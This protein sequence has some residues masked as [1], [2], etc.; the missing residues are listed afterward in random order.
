MGL[1]T[2]ELPPA[3]HFHPNPFTEELS[4]LAPPER[5]LR[6]DVFG[7]DGRAHG[8]Y[9]AQ[10]GRLQLGHLPGGAYV[11]RVSDAES[12]AFWGAQRVVKVGR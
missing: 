1:R 9:R 2:V 11:L 12:G 6:V 10:D 5:P 8:S 3:L 7:M 4:L